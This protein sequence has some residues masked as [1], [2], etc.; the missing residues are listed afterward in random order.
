MSASTE[1]LVASSAATTAKAWAAQSATSALAPFSIE[2]REPLASDVV[3]D[4]LYCGVC[5]SDLHQVR[6]E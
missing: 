3:I 4:I 2:R 6:D 5:H 1:S